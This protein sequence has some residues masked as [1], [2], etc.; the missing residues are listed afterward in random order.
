MVNVLNFSF[1]SQIKCWFSKGD[2]PL[3]KAPGLSLPINTCTKEGRQLH[4]IFEL[5]SLYYDQLAIISMNGVG[6]IGW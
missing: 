1:Y 3:T 6:G 4:C 2:N 5:P